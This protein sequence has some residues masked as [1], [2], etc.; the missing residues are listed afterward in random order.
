MIKPIINPDKTIDK[1]TLVLSRPDH[2]KLGAL[3][4]VTDMQWKR[5]E[6]GA[7]ELSFVVSKEINEMSEDGTE[8]T[9]QEPLWDEIVDFK[10]IYV[11]EWDEYFNLEV[12]LIEEGDNTKRCSCISAGEYELSNSLIYA[13]EINSEADIKRVDYTRPTVFYDPTDPENSLLNRAISKLPHWS[14]DHVDNSLKT[15]QRTFSV[16]NKK[17]YDFLVSEV[18]EEIGCLFKFDSAKRTISAYDLKKVC[19]DCGYRGEFSGSCPKC[20]STNIREYGKNTGVYV[21]VENI[22]N[23]VEYSTNID[24]VKNCFRLEAGDDNMTAAI[25]NRNPNGSAYIY[26][27]SDEQKHD[28]PAT[29]VKKLDSYDILR[30][31]YDAEYA[32]L[33]EKVYDDLDKISYYTSEMMPNVEHQ[34]TSAQEEA[35]KLNADS[36]SPVGMP[37][38]TKNTSIQTVNNAMESYAKVFIRSGWYKAKVNESSFEYVG[39]DVDQ[40]SY[41]YWTGNFKITNYSDEEDTAISPTITVKVWDK[42]H[43]YLE[44]KI[45]KQLSMEDDEEGTIF[46]VLSY[47]SLDLFKEAIKLYGLNRLK[48][49]YDA[50]QGCLDIMIE[51]DQANSNAE[52]Y[53]ELYIPYYDKLQ[54]VTKEM[55]LRS[56]T[57]AEYR[58]DLEATQARQREIQKALDFEAYLGKDLYKIFCSYKKE[59]LYSNPNYISKDLENKELFEN[60]GAFLDAASEELYKAGT[61]QHQITGDM[62]NLLEIEEF[63]GLLDNFDLGNWIQV[64]IDGKTYKLR[65][66]SLSW[67]EDEPQRLDVTFSDVEKIKYGYSDTQSILEKASSVVGS[68][69]SMTYQVKR[70]KEQT[71][72]MRDFV[73]NG[74][75][76]TTMKIVNSANN[77]N[78]VIGAT[79]LLARRKMDFTESLYDPYQLK[80]LSNGLYV[81]SDH[82][83]STDLAV[84]RFIY[85]DPDTGEQETRMGV[86]AENI[87]GRLILGNK[88]GIYSTDGNKK[89][90]FDNFGLKLEAIESDDGIYSKIFSISKTDKDGNT[91]EQMYMDTD[92]NLVLANKQIIEMHDKLNSVDAEIGNFDKV[93]VKEGTIEKL[94]TEYVRAEDIEGFSAEFKKLVASEAQFEDLKAN[95]ATIYGLLQAANA[96]IDNL[97]TNKIDTNTFNAYKADIATLF[98][99]YATIAELEAN[100]LKA[101]TAELTYAKVTALTAVEATIQTLNTTIANINTLIADKADITDLN[102]VTATVET[103]IADLADIEE[104]LAD[105]VTADEVDTKILNANKV[106]TDD[107]TAIHAIVDVLEVKYATIEQ[108]NAQV[109]RIDKLVTEKAT[110]KELEAAVANINTLSGQ[111]ANIE[112]IMSGNIGTGLLQTIHLTAQNFVGDDAIITSAMIK[113]LTADKIKSGS[114]DTEQVTIESG[115]GRMKIDGSTQQ[116][117]DENGKCRIQIGKDANGKFSF[118]IFDETGTGVLIDSKGIHENAIADG[119]IV[120]KHVSSTAGIQASKIAF[121]D[122]DGTKT[123]QTH[124][125]TEQGRID[126]LIRDTTIDGTKLKDKLTQV[127]STVN[128]ITTTVADIQSDLDDA[129]DSLTG[130]TSKVTT[131]ETTADGLSTRITKAETDITNANNTASAAS[132]QATLNAGKLDLL[133]QSG[134][135]ASSLVITPGALNA[136]ARDINL[137][138]KVTFTSLDTATQNKING[139]LSDSVVEYALSTSRTTA[140]T[141]GWATTSPTPGANQYVWQRTKKTST[142]GSTTYSDAVCISGADGKPGQDGTNGVDA[143]HIVIESSA[144]TSF[145]D[146]AIVTTLTAH[147]FK[148][149]TELNATQLASEGAIKWYL[150]GSTTAVGTGVTLSVNQV[151]SVAIANYTCRLEG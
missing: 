121:I 114:I 109:A 107:L 99:S 86:L 129:N 4:F 90:S 80:L 71:D 143:L 93:Y 148:G 103:L 8:E 110:V 119:L 43:T 13:L 138:G 151:A 72:M 16:S 75:D 112:S 73:S 146:K 97:T 59:D 69:D 27:F 141:T 145:I 142:S 87:V 48:S 15:L 6:N 131:I 26:Y 49:F 124:L 70:S 17:V 132:T 1:L 100:Y 144:G 47:K 136:I 53:E 24:A 81:T 140:P 122:Q 51:S 77:Q 101:D 55:D 19:I 57:I 66:L 3:A 44:Q 92:G 37:N 79:G 106:I 105:K 21:D 61:C 10:Y 23:S 64:G 28:M 63:K 96:S 5:N 31:S 95:N 12:N 113:D 46:D 62:I 150:N 139:T 20:E 98:A 88:L 130:L 34:D 25:I 120:D 32:E 74:L 84:G 2:V 78:I 36:V 65:L 52:L 134:N 45:A 39:E 18:A 125:T 85:T 33:I 14:V 9:I 35:N 60:A 41:G 22:L 137:T 94:L 38:V 54:A 149:G 83:K 115:D 91:T 116:F 102:V 135:D 147:V 56:A 76:A 117:F 50:I 29:L 11:Q 89:L 30:K 108:L 58:A 126:Q 42:Y 133:I 128:G 67:G 111:L 104:V 40:A 68:Y 7:N 127:T 82:W 118:T 123:L